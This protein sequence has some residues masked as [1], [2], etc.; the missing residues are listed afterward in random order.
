MEKRIIK[1]RAW[2][3]AKN[4]IVIRNKREMSYFGPEYEISDDGYIIFFSPVGQSPLGDNGEDRFVLMQFTGLLDKKGVE[5]YEGDILLNN[6]YHF[7]V[8]WKE[9]GFFLK[10][11]KDG[12]DWIMINEHPHSEV[13][14]NTYSNP[15]LLK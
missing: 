8:H 5:I 2:D 15:E 6:D 4:E 9:A 11:I 13:I 3:K 7:E 10:N 14:G 12:S 1:F